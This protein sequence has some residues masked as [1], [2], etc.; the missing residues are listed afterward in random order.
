MMP[1]PTVSR[2]TLWCSPSSAARAISVATVIR[3]P[4]RDAPRSRA[5][6]QS[7]PSAADLP[8]APR[9]PLRARQLRESHRASGV[10]L[11][12]R[13]A[14]FGPESELAAVGEARGGVHHHDGGIDLGEEAR[15]IRLVLGHDR[16]GVMRRVRPDVAERLV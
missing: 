2:A 16:L 12:R 10:E 3:S 9:E 5:P 13:D 4:F 15:G 14:D 1:K 7:M 11:L 8:G 6:V